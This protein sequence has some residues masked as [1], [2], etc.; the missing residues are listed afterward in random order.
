MSQF[1]FGFEKTFFLN[2]LLINNFDKAHNK[3]SLCER[4]MRIFF[5]VKNRF[6]Y[7]IFE[8]NKKIHLLKQ[9]IIIPF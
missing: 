3:E 2:I 4:S 5:I 8:Y 9:Y 6:G 1:F 7:Y